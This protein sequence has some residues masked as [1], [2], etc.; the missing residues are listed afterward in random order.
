MKVGRNCLNTLKMGRIEQ[1]EGNKKI[2]KRGG[3]AGSRG[4]CLKKGAWNPLTNYG[5]AVWFYARVWYNRCH[6]L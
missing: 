2:L 3:G 4:G 5:Y 1:R 6:I